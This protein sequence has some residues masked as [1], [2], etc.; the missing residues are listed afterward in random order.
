MNVLCWG[1]L[2]SSPGREVD[3]L[4]Q[5]SEASGFGKAS[6][7]IEGYGFMDESGWGSWWPE[8]QMFKKVS[9]TSNRGV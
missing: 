1:A 7:Q 8:E 5:Q 4:V 6:K 9:C 3:S 2:R